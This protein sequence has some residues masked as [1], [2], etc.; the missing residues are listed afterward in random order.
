MSRP[1][2]Y[3]AINQ[4]EEEIKWLYKHRDIIKIRLVEKA[5]GMPVN[6]ISFYFADNR[7]LPDKWIQPIIKWVSK[8]KK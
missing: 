5:L 6:T 2:N 1:S 3:I 7:G 8:F 4:Q